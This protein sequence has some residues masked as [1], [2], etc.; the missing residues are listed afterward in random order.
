[1]G[2][3]VRADGIFW[4]EF[5]DFCTYYDKITCCRLF[6]DS[7]LS[8]PSDPKYKTPITKDAF[9]SASWNRKKLVG[10]WDNENAGKWRINKSDFEVRYLLFVRLCDN[11]RWYDQ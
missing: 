10:Q 2:E 4:M 6:N 1:M 3:E 9:P 7:I 11:S 8:M 5:K